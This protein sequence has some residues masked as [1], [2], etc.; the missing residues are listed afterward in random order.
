M[1][2]EKLYYFSYIM[3][4]SVVIEAQGII[5]VCHQAQSFQ[6]ILIHLNEYKVYKNIHSQN[7]KLI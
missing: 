4:Q 6:T 2:Y 1:G 5:S 3:K 7:Y